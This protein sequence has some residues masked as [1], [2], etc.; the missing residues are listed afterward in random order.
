MSAPAPDM[1]RQGER[2]RDRWRA[3]P[4]AWVG[5]ALAGALIALRSLATRPSC[6]DGYVRLIDVMPAMP[7]VF[8]ILGIIGSAVLFLTKGRARGVLGM[9]GLVLT[10]LCV[11]VTVAVAAGSTTPDAGCWTF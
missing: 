10:C 2:N 1:T 6:P 7:F 4:L 5:S 11:A 3:A 9:I 8:T